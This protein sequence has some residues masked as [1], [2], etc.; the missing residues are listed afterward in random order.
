[1]VI[2]RDLMVVAQDLMEIDLH[3]ESVFTRSCF[4]DRD[5]TNLRLSASV[6]RAVEGICFLYNLEM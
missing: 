4:D 6:S 5:S 2:D 1:M 3:V